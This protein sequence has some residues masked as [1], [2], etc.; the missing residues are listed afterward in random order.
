M[1]E[2][3]GLAAQTVALLVPY[4]AE[5]GKSG[6]TRVGERVWVQFR[7]AA[8]RLFS[9]VKEKFATDANAAD[10]LS[11]LEHDPQSQGRQAVVRELLSRFMVEDRSLAQEIGKLVKAARNAGGDTIIQT[12][13]VSGGNVGDITQIGKSEGPEPPLQRG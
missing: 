4:L 1:V 11:R 12:V 13:N 9:R 10:D 8:S 2:G 5:A 7:G 6:A 3:N